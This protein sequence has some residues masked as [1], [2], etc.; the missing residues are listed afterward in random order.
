MCVCMTT[1]YGYVSMCIGCGECESV[2]VSAFKVH[3]YEH[4]V[5]VCGGTHGA[6]GAWRG[7]KQWSD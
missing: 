1:M 7:V 2:C 4:E 3:V 5:C 6:E